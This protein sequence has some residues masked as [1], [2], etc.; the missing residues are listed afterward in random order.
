MSSSA[1]NAIEKLKLLLL[2]MRKACQASEAKEHEAMLEREQR[3]MDKEARFND[4]FRDLKYIEEGIQDIK[5]NQL[6]T[7][8]EAGKFHRDFGHVT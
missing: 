4:F 1:S 8:T 2:D 5:A 3:S 6:T 7:D